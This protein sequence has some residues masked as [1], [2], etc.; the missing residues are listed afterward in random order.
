MIE[1]LVILVVFLLITSAC[2][3]LWSVGP[4][5]IWKKG[6]RYIVGQWV[7]RTSLLLSTSV[8]LIVVKVAEAPRFLLWGIFLFWIFVVLHFSTNLWLALEEKRRTDIEVS[9]DLRR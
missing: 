2:F 6:L 7:S 4:G 1:A 8:L 3:S 5:G 9:G